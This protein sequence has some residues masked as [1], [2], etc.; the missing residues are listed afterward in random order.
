[1]VS[2]AGSKVLTDPGKLGPE[3]LE[4]LV[5]RESLFLGHAR[6]LA[7]T[8]S[9]F[10]ADEQGRGDN[11]R[12]KAVAGEDIGQPVGLDDDPGHADET[13]E[14]HGAGDHG[15]PVPSRE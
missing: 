4:L 11:E 12:P 7:A 8:R 3:L 2:L 14:E 5:E 6:M 15:A 10:V 1:M 9:E 13:R